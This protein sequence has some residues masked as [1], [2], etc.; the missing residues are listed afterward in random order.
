MS[1]TPQTAFRSSA[2]RPG[3]IGLI[4]EGVSEIW[5]RRRLIRYLVRA[6]LKKRGTDTLLGNVWWVIDPLLL[7]IVYVILVTVIRSGLSNPEDYPLFIFCAILPWKW[8]TASTNDSIA[9]VSGQERLIKQLHF[10]KVIFPVA[11][12]AAEIV[13][14]LF[15]LIPLGVLMLLL[16]RDRIS[17]W[18]LLIPVVALVQYAF[19]LALA[20]LISA[21]NVFYRDVANVS[22]HALRLWF[23]LSPGLYSVK[24]IE[25]IGR[26]NPLVGNVMLLNPFATF[27][28]SYRNVIYNDTAPLWGHLAAWLVASLVLGSLTLLFFKRVEPSFAKVL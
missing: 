6:D 13:G 19:T 20:F 5:S 17:P 26:T 15:G 23:Y 10:P 22:R 28:E 14:F 9:S 24:A 27:F 11:S 4:A 3:P 16:Y 7:M 18:L 21:V 12:S 8:F 1:A 2:Y 25:D